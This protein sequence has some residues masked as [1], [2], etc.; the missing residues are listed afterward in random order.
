MNSSTERTVSTI[1]AILF[2]DKR[3]NHDNQPNVH[4]KYNHQEVLKRDLK[5][6]EE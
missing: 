1:T 4:I 3:N 2:L 5:S 6:D